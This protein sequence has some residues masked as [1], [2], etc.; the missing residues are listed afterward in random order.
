[1]GMFLKTYLIPW[2]NGMVC[3]SEAYDNLRYICH[4]IVHGSGELPITWFA[5][6]C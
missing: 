1:M 4:E 6:I 3:V 5:D 2:F